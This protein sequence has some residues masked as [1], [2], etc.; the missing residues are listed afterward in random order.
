MDLFP[1]AS[2]SAAGELAGRTL[3]ARLCREAIEE[4]RRVAPGKP[5]RHKK[6]R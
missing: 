4:K 3:A 6:C 5:G 2:D 1:V